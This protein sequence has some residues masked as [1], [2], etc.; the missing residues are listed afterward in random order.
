MARS[1]GEGKSRPLGTDA[2]GCPTG[3]LIYNFDIEGAALKRHHKD[4]LTQTVL[5]IL[6]SNQG[7]RVGLVGRA[8]RSGP[9]RLNERLSRQRVDAVAAFLV[10]GG[11]N[12]S[13]IET[14][15]LGESSPFSSANES[16]EDRSVEVHIQ[17]ARNLDL[18]LDRGWR[19][20]PTWAL[21]ETVRNAFEPLATRA[22]RELR[23]S[24]GRGIVDQSGD[25]TLDFD[26]GGRET[27]PC[28]G[29]LILG[30]EG[31]GNIFVGAHES[32]RVCGGVRGDPRDPGGVDFT[33]QLEHVFE[34]GEVEFA[35]FVGNTC[36]HE[37]AHLMT[38]MEHTSDPENFMFSVGS[39]G[40]NLPRERRTL[41]SMRR[42]WGG[43]KSFNTQQQ[44]KLVCA[45]RTGN[46][47]GGIRIGGR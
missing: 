44:N 10:T 41:E 12:R 5:H 19:V 7:H 2:D 40:A 47:P 15:F 33:S 43:R 31:G 21:I 20:R 18:I 11:M 46:F 25:L 22:G 38:Q 32:L 26:P 29:I 39:L 4:F 45:M 16:E 24:V 28:A 14:E 42:H 9:E 17:I 1:T 23:I 3:Y 36:V 30:N 35:Q 27:R 6:D 34:N 8:S 37:L 13:R